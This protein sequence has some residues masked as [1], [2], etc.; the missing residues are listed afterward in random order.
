MLSEEARLACAR[1]FHFGEKATLVSHEPHQVLSK[2][3]SAMDE[4][5][6]KGIVTKAK[7]NDYGSIEFKGTQ[8]AGEIANEVMRESHA[9]LFGMPAETD[10]E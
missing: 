5:V 8:R 3:R 7:F 9:R 10:K 1:W 6:D 2:H 4:L